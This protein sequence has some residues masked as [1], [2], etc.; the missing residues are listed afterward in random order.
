MTLDAV[1][2][3]MRLFQGRTDDFGHG[4]GGW[5][6]RPLGAKD[7]ADHLA[8]YGRGIGVAP[9]LDDGTCWFAAVDLDDDRPEAFEACQE[10]QAFLGFGRTFVERSRSGNAHL[11][12]F[13]AEPIE[14]WI[15]RGV[16]KRAIDAALLPPK[17]EV[18]PKQD[19]LREGMVGNYVNLPYHGIGSD[20]EWRRP[21]LYWREDGSI[22]EYPL[23]RFLEI[24]LSP[25][26]GF[27]DPEAWR[28][29]AQ[30]LQLVSPEE[31]AKDATEQGTGKELHIC[32]EWIVAN[33]ESNP[34][35]EGGRHVVYFNLAKMLRHYE[36][37]G[38][39]E[40]LALLNMVNDA[41]PDPI[42]DRELMRVY[43]NAAGFTSTGCDDALMSPYVHP[44]CPIAHPT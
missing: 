6:G 10:M 9:L 14:A 5:V 33:R 34:V 41:S 7:Y 43:N 21:M 26:G 30:W 28:K 42:S 17:T 12:A 16:L 15:A 24:A 11:W 27:N 29:R 19:A 1:Q 37:F 44:E 22:G 32:A 38:Q 3:F 18:F 36:G 20:G 40:E 8:G 13:F 4:G 25:G 31:R 2:P 35:R 23:S 39:E